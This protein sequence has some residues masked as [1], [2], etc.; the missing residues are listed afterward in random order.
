[1]SR[2]EHDVAVLSTRAR[3]ASRRQARSWNGS[4]KG[5]GA[6]EPGAPS[7]DLRRP[8]SPWLDS[9]LTLDRIYRFRNTVS[10]RPLPG[11]Q[12]ER[13]QTLPPAYDLSPGHPY[14]S[15]PVQGS[16]SATTWRYSAATCGTDRST[17]STSTPPFNTGKAHRDTRR[18]RR[19]E[20]LGTA[21]ASRPA[22]RDVKWD[23]APSPDRLTTTS[24]PR[25][26]CARLPAP[27][28]GRHALL[29]IDY[30]EAHYCKFLPTG[31]S[32]GALPQRIIWEYDYVGRPTRGGRPSTTTSSSTVRT[33]RATSSTRRPSSAFPTW[34]QGWSGRERRAGSSPRTPGGTRSCRPTAASGPAPER[35]S[36]SA[37]SP[38]SAGVLPPGRPRARFLRRQG[39]TGEAC[40]AHKPPL[41][42]DVT[43]H[44]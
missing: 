43:T 6:F 32:S 41:H 42:P 26:V 14:T 44:P 12:P 37:S 19:C 36:R 25:P 3:H 9:L 11:C 34:P 13:P 2:D 17:S 1:M 29:H 18:I 31:S 10:V 15:A 20:R 28:A 16:T 7:W 35:R 39:T 40:L 24:L 8:L 5:L 21:W 4:G 23:R 38:H 27:G 33:D 30:R 22:L